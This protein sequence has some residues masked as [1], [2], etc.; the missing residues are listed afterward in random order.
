MTEL[1]TLALVLALTGGCGLL[2]WRRRIRTAELLTDLGRALGLAAEAQR[3]HWRLERRYCADLTEL[4]RIRR[5]LAPFVDGSRHGSRT[6][7]ELGV[8]EDGSTFDLAILAEPVLHRVL[9]RSR[10]LGYKHLLI[11]HGDHGRVAYDTVAED[12]R[13]LPRLQPARAA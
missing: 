12:E 10:R 11:A 7:W 5:E 6:R 8:A 13:Y 9:H 4:A 1:Q 2:A 3:V